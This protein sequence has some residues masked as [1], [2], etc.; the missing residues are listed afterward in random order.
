ML[1][2]PVLLQHRLPLP[3]GEGRIG[4]D[5]DQSHSLKEPA[6]GCL[7]V[8]LFLVGVV[9]IYYGLWNLNI[10]PCDR[11][12]FTA[13]ITGF[14]LLCLAFNLLFAHVADSFQNSDVTGRC[15]KSFGGSS[16]RRWAEIHIPKRA[17][18]LLAQTCAW[19]L[20]LHQVFMRE[21][22]AYIPVLAGK[23]NTHR[24]VFER[25]RLEV[26]CVGHSF[27][28][29]R[30]ADR[31]LSAFR[32]ESVPTEND[33]VGFA[34]HCK[35]DLIARYY[36]VQSKRRLRWQVWPIS[37]LFY[38]IG[39]DCGK[40]DCANVLIP[41]PTIGSEMFR[42][43]MPDV[44]E[45]DV[46]PASVTKLIEVREDAIVSA[47][48]DP[49]PLGNLELLLRFCQL[50][51]KDTGLALHRKPLEEGDTSIHPRAKYGPFGNRTILVVLGTLFLLTSLVF[52]NYGIANIFDGP[53][54]WRGPASLWIGWF[55][56]VFGLW[57]FA[58][59]VFGL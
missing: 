43:C 53:C 13:V 41:P 34:I 17:L 45:E 57:I 28:G 6:K 25:E 9:A 47:Y 44:S 20:L 49:R 39:I 12:G 48:R 55:P 30:F 29:K 24:G 58:Y 10:G 40:V 51:L 50:V 33:H 22:D 46:Y 2:V 38:V 56:F 42:R 35:S 54:D 11:R 3:I 37:L 32:L 31:F 23:I 8:C 36:C 16:A 14:L 21:S 59:R 26:F 1:G 5:D 15:S 18:H 27:Y 7:T 4:S 19:Q 52:L